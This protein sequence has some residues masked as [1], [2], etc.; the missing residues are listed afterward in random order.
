[1]RTL[2]AHEI[3]SVSG[4][5]RFIPAGALLVAWLFE[6]RGELLVILEAARAENARLNAEH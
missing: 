3:E 4:G 2:E 1:M 5:V 6:N